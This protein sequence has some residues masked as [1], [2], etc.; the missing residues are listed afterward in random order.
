MS[1][2]RIRELNDAFRTTLRGGK[3]TLTRAMLNLRIDDINAAVRAMQQFDHFDEDNDPFCEHDFGTFEISGLS[4]YFK[5]EYFDV[6]GKNR[7]PDPSRPEK[8]R[9]VLTLGMCGEA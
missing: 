6:E 9:R 8:T 4:Y 3:F 5:I 7:S 2:E 1:R